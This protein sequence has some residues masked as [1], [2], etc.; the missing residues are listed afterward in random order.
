MKK[1]WWEGM[2]KADWGYFLIFGII[3]SIVSLA[4]QR[5]FHLSKEWTLVVILIP[6]AILGYFY[7]KKKAN[8]KD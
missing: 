8:R 4:L 1:N 5:Y 3:A 2:S 7:N 6:V